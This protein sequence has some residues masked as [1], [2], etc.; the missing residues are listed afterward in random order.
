MANQLN[1]GHGQDDGEAE[2]LGGPEG[3]VGPARARL[4]C[5]VHAEVHEVDGVGELAE[6]H[7]DAESHEPGAEAVRAEHEIDDE[8]SGLPPWLPAATR[9]S[10]TQ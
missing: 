7:E 5:Q 6:E 8:N 3:P 10:S 2:E 1:G 9:P 4:E